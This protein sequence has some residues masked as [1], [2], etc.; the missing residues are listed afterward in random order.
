MSIHTYI[1]TYIFWC[2]NIYCT[3]SKTLV[4][5]YIFPHLVETLVKPDIFPHPAKP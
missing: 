1:H 2:G 5:H 3:S 4:K